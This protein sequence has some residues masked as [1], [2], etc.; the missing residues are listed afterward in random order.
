[1]NMKNLKK[2]LAFSLAVMSLF[3]TSVFADTVSSNVNSKQPSS[4]SID[5]KAISG[6]TSFTANGK[7]YTNH[8]GCA[9]VVAGVTGATTITCK[10]GFVDSGIM[11]AHAN[12]YN[13]NGTVVKT[14]GWKYN[15]NKASG[16]SAT[17]GSTISKGTYYTRGTTKAYDGSG[18][19][20][21]GAKQSP[22]ATMKSLDIEISNEELKERQYLY[23]TK[24]MISAL[25]VGDVEGYVYLDDLYSEDSQPNTPEEAVAYMNKIAKSNEKYK[26]IPLYDKDGETVIGEYHIDL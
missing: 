9:K 11:G 4:Y 16:F 7:S 20:T 19:K 17:T 5:S 21:V 1:M 15:T 22:I 26:S 25:G 6:T 18:Y 2:T 24:N 14:T 23:E 13:T 3:S 8:T 12:L 10:S